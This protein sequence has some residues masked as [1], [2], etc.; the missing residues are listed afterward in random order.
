MDL[1]SSLD[2]PKLHMC[3]FA[4]CLAQNRKLSA[5]EFGRCRTSSGHVAAQWR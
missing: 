4:Q 2:R 1:L 3:R 5:R